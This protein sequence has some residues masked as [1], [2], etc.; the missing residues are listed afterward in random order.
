MTRA[1]S[2]PSMSW[3]TTSRASSSQV[4]SLECPMKNYNRERRRPQPNAS[5]FGARRRHKFLIMSKSI[6][7]IISDPEALLALEPE[8]LAG[9]VLEHFNSMDAHEQA[10]LNRNNFT[11]RYMVE[12]YPAAYQNRILRALA[13]AWAWLE[14]EGLI[15]EKPASE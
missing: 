2:S 5:A 1:A 13:E 15:A 3:L 12:S 11:L 7:S 4:S 6:Y 14:R 8:E 9:V 10:Q